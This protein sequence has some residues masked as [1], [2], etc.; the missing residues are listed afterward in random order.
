MLRLSITLCIV[1]KRCVLQQKLQLTAYKKSIG[2]KLNDL[3]LCRGRLRSCKPLRHICHWISRIPLEIEAWLHRTTNRKWPVGIEWSRD[4]WRHVNL[5]GQV[6]TPKRLKP[7]ISKT[8]GGDGYHSATSSMQRSCLYCGLVVFL[9]SHRNA[10]ILGLFLN[11]NRGIKEA[12]LS[13]G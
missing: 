7:D 6:M 3:D 8:A 5:K 1:P 11:L 9:L 4:W 10:R 13:L 2:T 12:K